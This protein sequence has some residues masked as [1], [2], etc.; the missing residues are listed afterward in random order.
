METMQNHAEVL[1][2]KEWVITLLI[3]AIPLVGFIMLFV[4]G[5][6][7]GAHPGKANWAKAMLLWIVILFVFYSLIALIFGVGMM[8]ALV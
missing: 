6:G 3:T 1:S 5:F 2:I 8:S 7:G 4:W